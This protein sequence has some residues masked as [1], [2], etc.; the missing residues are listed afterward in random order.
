MNEVPEES[1][2]NIE[3]KVL[4]KLK[5]SRE[6]DELQQRLLEKFE[7][8]QQNLLSQLQEK[9]AEVSSL[10]D[11]LDRLKNEVANLKVTNETRASLKSQLE[12]AKAQL[13]EQNK[14]S[15]AKEFEIISL[16]EEMNEIVATNLK[17][18]KISSTLD[19]ILSYHRS[20][21]VNTGLGYDKEEITEVFKLP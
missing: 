10:K 18:K 9:N 15:Q 11:E 17:F 2:K 1:L 20:L 4:N 3:R 19:S 16:K 7:Q 12:E 14:V 8:T 6:K 21:F 13:L 5:K